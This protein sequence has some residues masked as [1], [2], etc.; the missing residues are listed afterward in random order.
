MA[1][2]LDG[3]DKFMAKKREEYLSH[4]RQEILDRCKPE[5]PEIS[6]QEFTQMASNG[7]ERQLL[8][9]KL[10][11]EALIMV[12]ATYLPN[13]QAFHD[14]ASTYSVPVTYDA[15]LVGKLVPLLLR[16]ISKHL[17]ANKPEHQTELA[18]FEKRSLLNEVQNGSA[19]EDQ[20]ADAESNADT[21]NDI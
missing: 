5:M 14:N 6:W 13:C 21:S 2:K 16:R 19:S 4:C 15:V 17:A 8:H 18:E 9:E 12:M 1:F 10:S 7:Y 11:L 20:P 3:F